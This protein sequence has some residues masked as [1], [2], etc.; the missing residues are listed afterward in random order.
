M[1]PRHMLHAFQ[2][3][4]HFFE[5]YSSDCLIVQLPT[6][7]ISGNHNSKNFESY[8]AGHVSRQV[9]PNHNE[10]GKTKVSWDRI[11]NLRICESAAGM[12]SRD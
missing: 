9:V 2:L 8:E 12:A 5:P 7:Q 10:V 4:P 1:Y 11:C 6:N 3:T